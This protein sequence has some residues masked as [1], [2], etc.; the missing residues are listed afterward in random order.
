MGWL[1]IGLLIAAAFL[2]LLE[3]WARTDVDSAKRV[4]FWAAIGACILLCIF[5]VATGRGFAALV[6]VGI[7]LW[8]FRNMGKAA[9][10]AGERVMRPRKGNMSRKEALEVLG[11]KEGASVAEVN[12]AYRRLMAV[13]HP[14]KGG[15]DWMAA[16]LNEARK[17]LLDD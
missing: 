1:L 17:V 16:K 6:P 11:L 8:R 10:E 13:N 3:W 9:R 5:L 4:L 15:S 14:D 12:T 7:S 2:I